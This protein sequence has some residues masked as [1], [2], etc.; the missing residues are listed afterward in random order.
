MAEERYPFLILSGTPFERGKT[1][2]KTFHSRI[3][4]SLSNY[5]QMF[6][7]FNDVDWEDAGRR[8]MVF[9]PFIKNF[10]PK[11]VEEMEGIAEGASLDFRD[12]LILN[13]RSE[14][15]LDSQVDG[16][17]A[18]ATAHPFT[19]DGKTYLCQNWDWIRRQH[20]SLVVLRVEQ[21]PEPSLLIIAEAGIISGKGINSSGLGVAFN[22]L[23]TGSGKLGIPVHIILR[24]IL[25]SRCL[26]D[27]VQVVAEAQR[28]SSG[29]FTIGSFEGELINIEASPDDFWVFYGEKGWITH[30]NHFLATFIP[31]LSQ[32]KGKVI[33]PDTFQR[34]GRINALLTANEGEIDLETCQ[35]ML[36][37]HRNHPD[38]ICRHE[39]PRDPEGKQLASV[40]GT[41]MDLTDGVIWISDPNPCEGN[42]NAYGP[43]H[44]VGTDP[45][46]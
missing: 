43:L 13:S 2:G 1:Y 29:N 21:E 37:D 39:D 41:V 25:D 32:D 40:Y 11:M 15:V 16:C 38:S 23:T 9:L 17:T 14:I 19:R 27:A 12:I 4:S 28:A 30:T 10:S 46:L 31:G 20:D 45:N 34:L 3:E 18:F 24:A 36:S 8:A 44:E 33:L 26:S 42:F 6:R 5:R 35:V 22:A 7:A